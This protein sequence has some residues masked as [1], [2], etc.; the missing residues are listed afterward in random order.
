[1]SVIFF[2]MTSLDGIVELLYLAFRCPWFSLNTVFCNWQSL[3]KLTH[4]LFLLLFIL[5]NLLF[6]YKYKEKGQRLWSQG[7]P[8]FAILPAVLNG[9]ICP[10]RAAEERNINVFFF[11]ILFCF[12]CIFFMKKLIQNWNNVTYFTLEKILENKFLKK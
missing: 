10:F 1:M 5:F 8:V 3:I 6:I 12:Y 7:C 2:G 4:V 11:F 9:L